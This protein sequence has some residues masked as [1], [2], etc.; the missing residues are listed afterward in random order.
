MKQPVQIFNFSLRNSAEKTVDI[1]IDGDIVDASTQAFMKA[2][3]GETTSTSYQSFR[4]SLNAVDADI[5]NIYINSDGGHVGDALAMHD[6]LTELQNKG[7]IVNTKG[8]GIIASSATLILLASNSPEMS[9][10]SFMMIHTVSGGVYGNVKEVKNFA[11]TM[12]TFNNKIV[13]VYSKKTGLTPEAINAMMEDE[14]WMTAETAKAKGFITNIGGEVQFENRIEPEYW[15]HQDKSILNLYNKSVKPHSIVDDMKK[16]FNDFKS[17]ITA[18]IK[19]VQAPE[20]Q[21]TLVNSI[22]DA[23]GTAFGSLGEQFETEVNNHITNFLGTDAGKKVITD[24]LASEAGRKPITDFLT[25]DE[26]KKLITDSVDK[27]ALEEIFESEILDNK[28]GKANDKT[29]IDNTKPVGK[30][31]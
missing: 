5:Y 23:V 30:F 17:T 31:A 21:K 18:A 3:F 6:L 9:A 16:L 8:R 29:K 1:F 24:F 13:D 12:E 25:S 11:Q 10:N 4:N 19:G 26:G 28:G 27:E 14:T 20:E 2:L 22:A 7:K 15:M